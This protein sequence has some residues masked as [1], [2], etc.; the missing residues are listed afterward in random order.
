MNLNPQDK[1]LKLMVPMR[2]LIYKNVDALSVNGSADRRD[3]LNSAL[4]NVIYPPISE[5][6]GEILKPTVPIQQYNT[7]KKDVIQ[8]L[9]LNLPSMYDNLPR[10][11]QRPDLNNRTSI[12]LNYQRI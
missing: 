9:R 10:H 1:T 5:G 3:I 8:D 6:P 4:M 2:P 12:N 7:F 11:H